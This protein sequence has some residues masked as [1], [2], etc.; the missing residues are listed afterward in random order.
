[1]YVSGESF[2]VMRLLRILGWRRKNR[3]RRM[4]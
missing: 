4:P 2:T 1:M 3:L